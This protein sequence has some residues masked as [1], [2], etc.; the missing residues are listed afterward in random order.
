MKKEKVKEISKKKESLK[1]GRRKFL[2]TAAAGAA[3]AAAIGFPMVSRAQTMTLKMQGSWGAKDI[4][5]D[6]ANDYVNRVNEMGGG[7]LVI[8]YLVSGAVVKAFQVQDAV[9]KGV[10]DAAHSV[11]VYWYGKSKVASLFGTGPV[12]GQNAHQGL[13]WI[14]F[15][16]GLELYNELL[17]AL[18][19]DIVGFFT[20]PMPT[21]PLG[22]FKS[23]ITDAKQL[24]GLKYRTVGLAADLFQAMGTKVTQLPGG[25][26]VPALERGVI[27]AFEF[28]NPTSDR[29]FGAQ[30]VSK[31]YMLGSYHQAAEFFEIMFN[32]KKYNQ[33]PAEHK[34]ILRYAAE[35]SSS[36]SY[37]R[38]QDRYSEDLLWLRDKAGVNIYRTPQSVMEEQLKA[39][40]KI[41]PNLEKDPF[42]KKVVA[43]QKA[44]AHRV[45]YYELLNSCDYKLAF[46]HYFPGELKK[47]GY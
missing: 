23:Q 20:F 38:G 16:G 6:Y 42:F 28:N 33:L 25:E 26:I 44:F 46:N 32:R 47:A 1:V 41:L 36:Y 15:G 24:V 19:L 9:N 14:Y 5:N 21:Q 18:G 27:E 39:W 11:S 30:D 13:A 3:G 45:A 22:W 35:A 4:F 8:D 12:F 7:R 17:H 43:S 37:W 34:A 10:L 31:V 29:S 40:D 2:K